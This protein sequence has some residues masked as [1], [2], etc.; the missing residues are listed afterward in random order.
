[1]FEKTFE[2]YIQ[3]MPMPE[4]IIAKYQELFP[5]VMCDIWREYGICEF[6]DG[7]L[8]MVNPLEYMD[9]VKA[10]CF[11]G[12]D[13]IP[14]MV[15]AFGDIIVMHNGYVKIIK[16]K[17]KNSD[18]DVVSSGMNFFWVDLEDPESNFSDELEMALYNKVKDKFDK[19][20]FDECYAFDIE[21]VKK[22]KLK[23]PKIKIRKIKEYLNDVVRATGGVFDD[24]QAPVFSAL[25]N[26]A[27]K[28]QMFADFNFKLVVIQSL[29]NENCS[30]SNDLESMKAKY[31]DGKINDEYIEEM[32]EYFEN[33]VIQPG[34][35][36]LVCE[37]S[38]DGGNDIYFMIKPSWNGEKD[39]FNITSVSGFEKLRNLKSVSYVSMCD[40][41]LLEE[42]SDKGIIV[43]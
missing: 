13:S 10:T 24:N 33:L 30:F 2:N 4:E 29:L 23:Q 17:N 20:Q 41:E 27:D 16:Y 25:F 5:E 26:R 18:F 15:T 31:G 28:S 19:L 11:F 9:F 1:M 14:F 8:R 32:I 43:E 38:F 37:L 42:F 12:E 39:E 36:D 21:D 40:E 34:D 7:Y 35:L 22:G 3:I 6:C